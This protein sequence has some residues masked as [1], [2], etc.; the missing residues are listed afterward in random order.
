MPMMEAL[1]LFLVNKLL[2]WPV[3][4]SIIY[5]EFDLLTSSVLQQ[6]HLF[7]MGK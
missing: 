7:V 1:K 6:T 4:Y 2:I 5:Q 3:L